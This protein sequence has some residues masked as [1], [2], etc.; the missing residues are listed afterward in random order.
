V[1][2]HYKYTDATFVSNKIPITAFLRE[3]AVL[4]FVV[5][6]AEEKLMSDY[7]FSAQNSIKIETLA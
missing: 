3:F 1:K 4:E 6:D 7:R 5:W 2:A